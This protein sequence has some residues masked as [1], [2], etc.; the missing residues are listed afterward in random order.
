MKVVIN[1]CY[2]GFSLSPRAVAALARAKGQEPH[3]FQSEISGLHK[4]GYKPLTEAE[5]FAFKG[6]FGPTAYDGPDPET[7]KH[8]D[9]RPDDRSDPDLIRIVEELGDAANGAAAEL[10]IVEIPDGTDYVVEEYDGT[11]WI[12]ETHRTWHAG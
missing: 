5:A 10:A 3:W 7:A 6:F 12:A 8:I 9:S 11:E 4:I 1:R 2:G